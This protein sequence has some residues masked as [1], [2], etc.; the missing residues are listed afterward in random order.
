MTTLL[1]VVQFAATLGCG[2]M[3]QMR[4]V[5]FVVLFGFM[6]SVIG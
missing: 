2:L 4:W 1:L 6:G 5:M 3:A